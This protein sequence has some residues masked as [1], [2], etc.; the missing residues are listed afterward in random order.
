VSDLV[1]RVCECTE[2]CQDV[3]VAEQDEFVLLVGCVSGE[4]LA[5]PGGV[6]GDS[7]RTDLWV[8]ASPLTVSLQSSRPVHRPF[9]RPADGRRAPA[10]SPSPV[11]EAINNETEV[12]TLRGSCR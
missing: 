2:R 3:A 9:H 6:T 10:I 4:R 11:T 12:A 8:K 5:R 7:N 1:T